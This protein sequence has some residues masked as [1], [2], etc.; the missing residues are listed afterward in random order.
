MRID[1]L[2]VENFK[3]FAESEFALHPEFTL[4]VG[5][6]GTGKTSILEAL[7]VAAGSWFLGLRGYDTRHIRQDDVRL[8][9]F[10]QSGE[11]HWERQY[12]CA[13]AAHG[14]LL[15]DAHE[16]RRT[17]NSPDGRT[18]YVDA[19]SV[20]DAAE[21]ADEAVRSGQPIDLPLIAF[22]GTGRVWDTPRHRSRVSSVDQLKGKASLSR[23]EGYR[24][25][26]D[27]RIPVDDLKAWIARESWRTFQRGGISSPIFEVAQRGLIGSIR[28]ASDIYFDPDYGDVIVRFGEE[29]RPFDDL[30]DGQRSM[31]AVVGDLARRAATL[32]P[33]LGNR[34]LGETTGIVLIDELDMHLHPRWQRRVIEDLRTT[35]PALQFVCSTHSPFLIQSLR[36]GEELLLLDGQPVAR[37]GDKPIEE[38]ARGIQGVENPQAS[39][40]Y[41]EMKQAARHYLELL[42]EAA[43]APEDKLDDYRERLAAEIAPYADNPAYQAFLE[44]QRAGRLGR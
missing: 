25:S 7:S 26:V 5:E 41:L 29:Q 22:Y 12:P 34:A 10:S 18:T 43:A 21:R 2:V 23:L 35:F 14:T 31:L 32:N 8:A 6:N 17:L 11:M 37:L 9:G 24:T 16:W 1:R 38:I 33:H 42:E 13:V 36:S 28:G 39:E 19:R 20:K 4:V 40:R 27:P 3:C 30:S 44:L 15:G